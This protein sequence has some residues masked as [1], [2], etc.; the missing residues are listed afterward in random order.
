MSET[1]PVD[2][3]SLPLSEEQIFGPTVNH[4]NAENEAIPTA[5]ALAK[6]QFPVIPRNK[7]VKVRTRTGGEYTFK[8]APLDTILAT[9]TPVLSAHGLSVIQD[10][11]W[12]DGNVAVITALLHSSGEHTS[13][14]RMQGDTFTEEVS[15]DG[16]VRKRRLTMQELGSLL[17]YLRRYSLTTALCLGTEDDDDGNRAMGNEADVLREPPETTWGDPAWGDPEIVRQINAC[18]DITELAALWE[19]LT[20]DQRAENNAAKD[21]KKRALANLARKGN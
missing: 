9:I 11:E 16:D 15:R 3:V 19:T 5:L 14:A 13:L 10:T 20:T 6:G 12:G 21:A 17:T 1:N 18:R 8:Y 7:T 2:E 4:P